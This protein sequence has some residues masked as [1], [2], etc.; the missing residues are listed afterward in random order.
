LQVKI[1]DGRRQQGVVSP[2][3]QRVG[4]KGTAGE[5]RARIE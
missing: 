2:V 3:K 5:R 4:K 1:G